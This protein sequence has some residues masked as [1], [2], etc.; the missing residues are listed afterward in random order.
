MVLG[1]GPV[2]AAPAAGIVT[3]LSGPMFALS[4]DGR[5]KVL[6]VDS[7]LAANDTLFTGDAAFA[8]VAF[9][10]GGIVTLG[11]DT[12][13]VID[14]FAFD[15]ARPTGDAARFTLVEGSI[16]VAGGTIA[17]RGV[18]KVATAAGAVEVSADATFVARY[19]PPAH[20]SVAVSAPAHWALAS[21]LLTTGTLTDAPITSPAAIPRPAEHLAASNPP[22][23]PPS[24]GGLTPGL[25]VQVLD[26][27]IN[28]TNGGGTQNFTAGQFGFTPGFKQPPIV[29][30]TNPGLTFTPPPSFTSTSSAGTN[31]SSKPGDVDCIV[32]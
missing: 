26:G 25:Y 5:S 21:T 8:Q 1:A 31:G 4:T 22:G 14:A 19:A 17:K 11:P 9:A 3:Q 12:Q 7:V 18:E 15:A 10:D 16:R 20:S 6:A 2:V 27:L 32:R 28:V 23:S 29:L 13:L 24:S 30:P